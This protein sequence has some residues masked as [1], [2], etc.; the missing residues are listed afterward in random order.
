MINFD[1]NI[2]I[3]VVL[4]LVIFSSNANGDYAESII[5]QNITDNPVVTIPNA[6]ELINLKPD[7]IVSYGT[8][9]VGG[10]GNVSTS[11]FV[12]GTM[13]ILV[14]M[15]FEVSDDAVIDVEPNLVNEDDIPKELEEVTLYANIDN[16]FEFNGILNLI[17][18]K[19]TLYFEP[20]SPVAPD[21][22]AQFHLLAD[23]SYQEI[24]FLDETKFNLFTDS[25]YIKTSIDLL[26][27]TDNA[28][29][30][31]PTR[32]LK[33]DSLTIELYG[34]I[35]GLVDLADEEN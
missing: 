20:D 24:V 2:D 29:N 8:A 1:S 13:D 14:P 25:L 17:G 26:S 33:N 4:D 28:G 6:D 18:G 35:K 19:D 12:Q 7:K 16:H 27:N 31:I 3:P 21:T 9:S 30:P 22:I 10:E 5:R 11:Q 32:L 23:S 34:K 15:S